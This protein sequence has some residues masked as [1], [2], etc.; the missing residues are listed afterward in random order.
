LDIDDFKS[1]NDNYGHRVGD[2]A[3]IAVAKI[4]SRC[5]AEYCKGTP[6]ELYA[7]RFGGEEFALILPNI[8]E[9]EAASLAETIRSNIK[10][11]NFLIRDDKGEII[12]K[13]ISLSASFGVAQHFSNHTSKDDTETLINNADKAMYSAKNNGKNQVVQFGAIS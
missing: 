10:E 12:Q 3:L 13:G 2:Q 5:V 6:A 11:Y 4:I 7:T 8:A 1:F 9:P